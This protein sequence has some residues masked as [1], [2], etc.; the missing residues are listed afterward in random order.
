MDIT[1]LVEQALDIFDCELKIIDMELEHPEL[2]K[3]APAIAL[4]RWGGNV[5]DLIEYHIGPQA[6][7]LLQHPSGMP[8]T[9]EEAVGFI[10]DTYRVTV[11]NAS[12]RR[13]KILERVDN[14]SFTDKMR[15][16]LLLEA[17]KHN[18]S[19]IV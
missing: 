10:E 13:A 18:V 7:G 8:M 14:T 15:K 1:T 4:V 2:R 6:A 5:A 3:A 11:S 17:D 12:D 16:V 19:M 9:Y